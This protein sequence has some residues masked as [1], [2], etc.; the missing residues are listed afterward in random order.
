MITIRYTSIP[1]SEIDSH[2][3]STADLVDNTLPPLKLPN[4]NVMVDMMADRA[5]ASKEISL[6]SK[7]FKLQHPS[8][9]AWDRLE[10]VQNYKMKKLGTPNDVRE[11]R[12]VDEEEEDKEENMIRNKY[13]NMQ[14]LVV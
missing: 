2:G 8:L 13:L 12:G 5:L 3:Y 1:T 9:F 4:M 11:D 6:N 7:L 10:E 14:V